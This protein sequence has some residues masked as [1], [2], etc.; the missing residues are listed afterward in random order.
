MDSEKNIPIILSADI[1]DLIFVFDHQILGESAHSLILSLINEFLIIK[2]AVP[3]LTHNFEL[4]QHFALTEPTIS[5]KCENCEIVLRYAHMVC[6]TEVKTQAGGSRDRYY[7][8]KKDHITQ[9]TKTDPSPSPRINPLLVQGLQPNISFRTC[10]TVELFVRQTEQSGIVSYAKIHVVKLTKQIDLK[11]SLKYLDLDML[12]RIKAV[13][14]IAISRGL[15]D[16]LNANFAD[17]FPDKLVTTNEI[18][19][20]ATESVLKV[21]AEKLKGADRVL[22]TYPTKLTVELANVV[23]HMVRISDVPG[24]KNLTSISTLLLPNAEPIRLET[25]PNSAVV[26]PSANVHI[27][28]DDAITQQQIPV[29]KSKITKLDKKLY[30]LT[31]SDAKVVPYDIQSNNL[32]ACKKCQPINTAVEN[33][34]KTKKIEK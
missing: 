3:H 13:A 4:A 6:P 22:V 10:R 33:I 24:A 28:L 5:S 25:T 8:V 30:I 9:S 2:S 1:Y 7:F 34:I 27:G 31:G 29:P 26:F 18:V 11:T 12:S 17:T 23:A 16:A 32:S 20:E 21:Q 14:N 19:T 15:T